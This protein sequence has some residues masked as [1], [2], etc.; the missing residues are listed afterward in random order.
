MRR[1]R[2]TEAALDNFS[3]VADHIAHSSGSAAIA[4]DFTLRIRRRCVDLAS[5]PGTLGRDRSEL[6]PGIRSLAFRSYVIFSAIS[7]RF[8]RSSRFSKDIETSPPIST[9]TRFD[10]ELPMGLQ[11][12]IHGITGRRA[13]CP[14]GWKMPPAP[15]KASP[16]S[17]STWFLIRPGRPCRKRRGRGGIEFRE[18][19]WRAVRARH[20]RTSSAK[21]LHDVNDLA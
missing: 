13:R 21:S 2:Y 7:A 8:R 12:A 14:A 19:S 9:T 3:D 4:R 10:R 11:P 17:R 20:D 16:A 15:W 6:R 5:L 18:R 1:L